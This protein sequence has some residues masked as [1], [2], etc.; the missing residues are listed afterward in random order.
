M[1]FDEAKFCVVNFQT[2]NILRISTKMREHTDGQ[3]DK[4]KSP[5]TCVASKMYEIFRKSCEVHKNYYTKV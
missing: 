3:E 1:V 5:L 2:K 4:K